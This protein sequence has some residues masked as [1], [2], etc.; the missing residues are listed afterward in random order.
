MTFHT[1]PSPLR[2]ARD[3]LFGFACGVPVVGA[4]CALAMSW[5]EAQAAEWLGEEREEGDKTLALPERL[6]KHLIRGFNDG[7]WDEEDVV[8]EGDEVNG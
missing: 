8:Q 6:V 1:V 3:P 5:T 7:F 2:V 4:P